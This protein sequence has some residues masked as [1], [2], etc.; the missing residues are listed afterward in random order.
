MAEPTGAG[1]ALEET[2]RHGFQGDRIPGANSVVPLASAIA[3]S[4]EVG[5]RGG[6][7]ARRLGTRLGWQVFDRDML[8][9]AARDAATI[10]AVQAEL[11]A[12]ALLW[13]EE[14]L[15]WLH[16]HDVLSHDESFEDVARMI[17]ALGAKGEA[18]F[19]GH[20]AGFILPRET[21][22]HVRFV[23]PLPGRVAYFRQWLRLPY[24]EAA[25]QVRV[26]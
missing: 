24:D 15:R 8:E 7:I 3:V 1:H 12:A 25:E 21:T 16:Q 6:A 17:L 10:E 14:R 13:I 26:R 11:P 19:V 9:Y 2:P 20:G 22:L 18:I 23:A 5:A 4:R